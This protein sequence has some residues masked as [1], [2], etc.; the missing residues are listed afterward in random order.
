MFQLKDIIA[1]DIFAIENLTL[2]EDIIAII[3]QSGSGKS[4]LLR[5][6]NN[7]DDATSGTIL[8]NDKNLTEY[9]PQYLRRKIVMVPQSSVIFDGTIRKNLLI[10]LK[11]SKQKLVEDQTLIDMLQTFLIDKTLD[12]SASELSGGEQQRLTLARV[13]LMTQAEVFL[14]DEPTSDLDDETTEHVMGKLFKVAKENQQKIIMITHNK[15]VAEKYANKMINMDD[16]NGNL[17]S[18]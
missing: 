17:E 5:L 3:G 11:L 1:K 18:S 4:T 15:Q 14:L 9:S 10:G 2:K 13:L 16:Y 8:F 12:T 6:L 7:L